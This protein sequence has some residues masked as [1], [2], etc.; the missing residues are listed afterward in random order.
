MCIARLSQPARVESRLPRIYA[1]PSV[2]FFTPRCLLPRRLRVT[3][4][5]SD[6]ARPHTLATLKA[7]IAQQTSIPPEQVKLVYHGLVLK[8]DSA[9]LRSYNVR[10]GSR[11]MLIGTSGGV[12]G[13]RPGAA[14]AGQ[15]DAEGN[16]FAD[17]VRAAAGERAKAA[18][19]TQAQQPRALTKGEILAEER[20]RKEEDRTESGVT[21]RIDEVMHTVKVE[22]EP[23]LMEFEAAVGVGGGA[24]AA[25]PTP[26]TTTT[27]RPQLEQSQRLLNELLSRSLLNLDAIPTVSE[28][29]RL[30]RKEAV[31]TVQS[32]IDR[33]D[34]SWEVAKGKF[35]PAPA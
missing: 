13:D 28:G 20:R 31:R 5:P 19:G 10:S 1:D 33:L 34:R 12:S 26:A 2:P 3:L 25:A 23:K 7:H 8:D 9:S 22:I 30:R 24:A 27:T 29:T 15:G 16:P 11:L 35:P 4:P 14:G 32:L 18:Q 21:A 17:A 6:P